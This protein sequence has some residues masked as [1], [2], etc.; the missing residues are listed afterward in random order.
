MLPLPL[1]KTS[2]T[3][4]SVITRKLHMHTTCTKIHNHKHTN[5][6]HPTIQIEMPTAKMLEQREARG[7]CSFFTTQIFHSH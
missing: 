1:M 5:V 4:S 2:Y 7:E 3:T 6:T